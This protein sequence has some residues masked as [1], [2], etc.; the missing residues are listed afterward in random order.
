MFKFLH[1]ADIHFDAPLT[2][3]DCQLSQDLKLGQRK[4]FKRAIERCIDETVNGLIIA[5][6]L[7]DNERISLETEKFLWDQFERLREKDIS[8]YYAPGNHDPVIATR[9]KFNENIKIFDQDV[10]EDVVIVNAEGSECHLIGVGHLNDRE[11]RNLIR[12]FPIKTTKSIYI[13]IAHAM[14]ESIEAGKEKGRYLPTTLSDLAATDY[15]YWALGHIHQR[16]QMKDMPIYYSGTLQGLNINETGSKGGNLITITKKHVKVEFIPFNSIQ[17]E[18]CSLDISG[19]YESE[20]DFYHALKAQLVTAIAGIEFITGDVI[21]RAKLTG[22]TNMMSYLKKT[23]NIQYLE[24]ELLRD[25][26]IR[27]FEI[28]LERVFGMVSFEQLLKDNP[29]MSEII[30]I[31]DHPEKDPKFFEAVSGLNFKSIDGNQSVE[32]MI[33]TNRDELVEN[34]MAYFMGDES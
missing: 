10:P 19:E 14:V 5:G 15:D 32:E 33:R 25:L 24:D 3:K 9:F 1:I 23:E 30:E 31:I 2:N 29:V 26:G 22:R 13:G 7:F 17:Y 4:A 34:L 18:Q 21:L 16:M 8:V 28:K 12:K 6:D 27:S 20:L 11:K